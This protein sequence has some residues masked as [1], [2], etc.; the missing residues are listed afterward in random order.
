MASSARSA[1]LSGL[2]GR[3]CQAFSLSGG[4][5]DRELEQGTGQD[6]LGRPNN[7]H[8]VVLHGHVRGRQQ[9][10]E[11]PE[12]LLSLIEWYGIWV[13]GISRNLKR[14]HFPGE[15]RLWTG[16]GEGR[17]DCQLCILSGVR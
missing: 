17:H 10:L 8:A 6:A 14:E 9:R 11:N 5:D 4:A 13:L 15:P 2:S 16:H 12:Q 1:V 3:C 7:S